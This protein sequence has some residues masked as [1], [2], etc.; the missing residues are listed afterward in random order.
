M[1]SFKKINIG[2]ALIIFI[3]L[4]VSLF[5]TAKCKI[6]EKYIH[7]EIVESYNNGNIKKEFII[8]IVANDSIFI[9]KDYYENGNL[10]QKYTSI[11][12]TIH[13]IYYNEDGSLENS[14]RFVMSKDSAGVDIFTLYYKNGNKEKEH[15]MTNGIQNGYSKHWTEDGFLWHYS[16]RTDG[17][18]DGDYLELY[19]S[20]EIRA[21]AFFIKGEGYIQYYYE[22]GKMMKQG[23][24]SNNNEEGLW[25]FYYENGNKRSE[26]YYNNG[27]KE[28]TYKCW[29]KFGRLIE[30]GLYRND[31]IISSVRY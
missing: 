7:Y 25:T 2:H 11:Y 19:A 18:L 8:S 28:G 6:K 13:V 26:G 31:E 12:D 22:N 4:V 21:K 10:K 15:Q 20:G 1:K 16:Y 5:F 23:N 14:S 29:D 9:D 27:K 30:I 17:L 24:Y 3:V